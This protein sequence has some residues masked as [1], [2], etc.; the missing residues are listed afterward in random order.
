[1]AEVLGLL[2]AVVLDEIVG[3]FSTHGIAG[4]DTEHGGTSRAITM[5][6]FAPKYIRTAVTRLGPNFVKIGQALASR[7]DLVGESIA[8]E[9]LLL[10]DAMP[11]FSNSIARELIR[12]VMADVR[13]QGIGRTDASTKKCSRSR[14]VRQKTRTVPMIRL[15]LNTPC[16]HVDGR[17]VAFAG[18]RRLP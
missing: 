4:S 9:L 2:A 1:M 5:K 11:L 3:M 10:Q 7:P 8:G 15:A 17:L 18:I 16:P 14:S 13:R 6:M 12:E